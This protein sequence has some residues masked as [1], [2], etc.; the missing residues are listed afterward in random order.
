[1]KIFR[2]FFVL[3]YCIL[4]LHSH[5]T[6]AQEKKQYYFYQPLEYGSEAMFN[7]ISVLFNGGL[8][9]L[10]SYNSSTRA[11]DIYWRT[12]TTSVWQSIKS[13][14]YWI[15]RYGWNKF[16]KQEV[17]PT[18][19]DITRAQWIPNY[20]LHLFCGGLEYRKL[21]EWYQYNNFPAPYL[22]GAMTAMSYHLFNEIIENGKYIHGN[23]DAIADL[24]IFDPLG[25]ILFSFDNVAEFFADNIEFNDW[26]P[27][28]S[29]SFNPV[30][31]RN[32]SHSFSIRYPL[33][34]SKSIKAF[35]HFG[36]TTLAGLSFKINQSDSYSFGFGATQTGVWE[37][38]KKNGIPTHSIY[39]GASAGFFYDRN[40]SLLASLII[41]KY[42]YELLRFNIYPG[43][44]SDDIQSP[45]FF[46]TYG[47]GGIFS[48]G[49]TMQFSPLGIGLYI[50][51]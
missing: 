46:L 10:Q 9:V 43:F 1:M 38:D 42:H 11:K 20:A 7:P 19:I 51:R 6:R 17:L 40:N 30:A 41:A 8:D 25:I 5:T 13:P 49:I 48:I 47:E 27:Q 22:F 35:T 23:I 16:L 45:G 15:S 32:F 37:V 24:C 26:S 4:I 36:K 28:P 50:P 21:S 2:L 29:I 34:Q 44:L 3:L 31:F 39:I 18:S 12:G 14:A 33:T